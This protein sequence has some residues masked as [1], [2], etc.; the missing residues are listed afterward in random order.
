MVSKI[1]GRV[2]V[3]GIGG[4]GEKGRKKVIIGEKK[5]LAWTKGT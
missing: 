2:Q 4:R 3:G 5:N 1:V